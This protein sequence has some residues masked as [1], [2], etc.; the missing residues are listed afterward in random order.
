MLEGDSSRVSRSLRQAMTWAR[1]TERSSAMP[2]QAG[3]G[4]KLLD[5]D[6]IGAAGFGIGDVGEPFELGRH[7]GEVAELGRGQRAPERRR[8][9]ISDRNQVL[10]HAP[11][12]PIGLN[13]I[14]YFI[15]FNISRR[16][17]VGSS[18]LSPAK[19]LR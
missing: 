7:L 9:R 1:V 3:E 4:D 18:T 19:Y 13:M 12:L 17:A 8:V 15:M 11:P 2:P 5:V 10:F 14:M 16:Q 6:L